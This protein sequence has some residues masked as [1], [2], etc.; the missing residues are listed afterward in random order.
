MN[1]IESRKLNEQSMWNDDEDKTLLANKLKIE[2]KAKHYKTLNMVIKNYLKDAPFINRFQ[3]FIDSDIETCEPGE[4]NDVYQAIS[5]QL[6]TAYKNKNLDEIKEFKGLNY[7]RRLA[8][9]KSVRMYKTDPKIFD[10]NLSVTVKTIDYLSDDK[11]KRF[12]TDEFD[13]LCNISHPNIMKT[14]FKWSPAKD[15]D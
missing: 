4:L 11:E 7:I 15:N 3:K 10:V 6:Y 5:Y 12:S 1:K 8:E 13:L 14:Y 9:D 2:M